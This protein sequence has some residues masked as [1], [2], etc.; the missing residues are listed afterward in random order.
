MGRFYTLTALCDRR[1]IAILQRV[2]WFLG[3]IASKNT[4]KGILELKKV[5]NS[6]AGEA[7]YSIY[8]YTW[9]EK[10]GNSEHSSRDIYGPWIDMY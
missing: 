9:N 5:E 6:F 10:C 4:F 2:M 1:K 7:Y 8:C 3:S